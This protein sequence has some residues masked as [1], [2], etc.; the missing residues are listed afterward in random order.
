MS[1]LSLQM[2]DKTDLDACAGMHAEILDREGDPAGEE[3]AAEQPAQPEASAT[4]GTGEAK[5]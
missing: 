1:F 5:G 4:P 3:A 2:D